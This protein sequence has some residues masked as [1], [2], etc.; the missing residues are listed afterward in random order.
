MFRAS[1][2]SQ[3]IT[4]TITENNIRRRLANWNKLTSEQKI[5]LY[6]NQ[7]YR[8]KMTE[9]Q[10]KDVSNIRNKMRFPGTGRRTS[11]GNTN[12]VSKEN[13]VMMA[14]FLQF[15]KMTR[16]GMKDFTQ[17]ESQMYDRIITNLNTLA[18]KNGVVQ[19]SDF[20]RIISQSF[21]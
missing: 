11:N 14:K 5:K 20:E 4:Q 10:K 19:K 3:T 16:T 17:K 18:K 13:I 15:N 8:N 7:A 21:I 6:N 1:Q 9:K 2:P 12:S